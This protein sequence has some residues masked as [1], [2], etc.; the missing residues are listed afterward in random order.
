MCWQKANLPIIGKARSNDAKVDAVAFSVWGRSGIIAMYT[1]YL[2]EMNF[3]PHTPGFS[4][5]RHLRATLAL[6]RPERP[7]WSHRIQVELR[8]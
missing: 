4:V 1:A 3:K 5:S 7:D 2:V 8:R 6:S